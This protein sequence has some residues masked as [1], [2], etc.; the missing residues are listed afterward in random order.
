[1]EKLN[2]V[3][4]SFLLFVIMS[5]IVAFP[6]QFSSAGA[7]NSPPVLETIGFN[8]EDENNFVELTLRATDPDPGDTLTFTSSVLPLFVTLIDKGDKKA[9]L[10][11]ETSCN[12]TG[13]YSI[14]ITVTDDGSPNLS[15]DET[16]TL[17]I[18]EDCDPIQEITLN[19]NDNVVV[20]PGEMVV[21][22][23][24]V[25]IDGDL[26]VNGGTVVITESSTIKGNIESNGGSILIEEGS[27]IEGNV[28]IVVSGDGGV[29]EINGGIVSG[30]LI[31]NGITTLTITNSNIN[32]N[33]YSENDGDVTITGN[34]VNGNIEILGP[35]S[36]YESLNEVNG[37]NSSCHL[38]S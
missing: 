32:G 17:E 16:F 3:R 27:V 10:L 22:S 14:T 23:N 36:C 15:D 13:I 28:D 38:S 5:S 20:N 4:E 24:S 2:F 34:T 31:T 25:T 30:N 18:L 8:S 26:Q 33:I 6:I 29:L 11:F 7:V 1:M 37:N 9:S 19:V 21:I 35:Q 12:D